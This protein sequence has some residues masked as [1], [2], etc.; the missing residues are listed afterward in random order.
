[1]NRIVF[2]SLLQLLI[3]VPLILLSLKKY[4]KENYQRIVVFGVIFLS[5]QLLINLPNF[6]DTLKFINGN[7]NWD[8]KIFGILF[9][10]FCYF[11]FR[12]LFKDYDYFTLKQDKSNFKKV[13][14]VSLIVIVLATI[15]WFFFG[16]S[17]FNIESLAFQLT[18]PGI[19]EEIMYRGILLGLLMS[20]LKDK[21]KIIGNPSVLITSILFGLIHALKLD[22][23]LTPNFNIIYFLQTGLAGYAW[24]WIT[25][26]SR[27]ILFAI[28]SHNFSNFFGTLATM[29]K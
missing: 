5:Y 18:L 3:V 20:G 29:I 27:S 2:E 26:K 24:G 11:L 14:I 13:S 22:K 10:I 4:N 28:L 19:D 9:G 8:G 7:W 17:E 15:I 23:N 12:K 6:I 21:Q 16:E 25:V 1:M